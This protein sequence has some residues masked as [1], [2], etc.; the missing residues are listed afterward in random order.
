M[1]KK[2]LLAKL[3]AVSIVLISGLSDAAVLPL[4]GRLP[5]TPGGD[6][7]QAYYDPN[8]DV[9][10][11]ADANIFG[12]WGGWSSMVAN[13]ESLTI[14]GIGDWRLPA[15][16]NPD[17]SCDTDPALAKGYGCTGSEMG[18]LYWV[19]GIT[20]ATPGPFSNIQSDFYWSGT[21][22]D[23]DNA[24]DFG[25]NQYGYQSL[26]DKV[27]YDNYAWAVRSGDVAAVP[28]PT[29]LWLFVSGLLGLVGS[30]RRKKTA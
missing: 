7:Y 3:C 8:L 19:E 4:E 24:W 26:S 6:D 5:V 11:A 23:T 9:T 18:Y 10:W 28:V 29:T 2:R 17:T 30:A 20:A 27:E 13:V 21:E 14:S 16:L 15:T 1:Q 22:Y 12:T 25:F